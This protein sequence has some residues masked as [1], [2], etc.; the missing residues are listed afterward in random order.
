MAEVAK[1]EDLNPVILTPTDVQRL[2]TDPSEDSRVGVLEK[3]SVHYNRAAFGEREHEIA[4]QIFRLLMKDAAIRVRETLADRIKNNETI[5][6]DI[7]LHMAHDVDSV[8]LPLLAESKVFS[9][10]DLVSIVEASRDISKLLTISKRD[11]VSPRVSDALVETRYPEVV[12]T[13]LTN[14]TA[15]IGT[16]AF[17]KIIDD[18]RGDPGVMESMVARQQ[19]PLS[20]VERLVSEASTAVAAQLKQKYNLTDAQ[21]EKDTARD[22]VLMNLLTR[23]VSDAEIEAMVAQMATENRLTPSLVMTALCRGQM[24]FF[25]AAM[26]RFAGVPLANAKRLVADKGDLGLRGLYA[27]SELPPAMFDAVRL[28]LRAVQE[29]EGDEAIP[30]SMLYANRLVEKVL[31]IAGQQNIEYLPYFIA[32][33]RQNIARH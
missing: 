16:R 27:K 24:G 6:R 28:L 9:D 4:E 18:F 13:L 12:S 17:E 2:L 8:A 21:L 32:L 26:G 5:P 7:V 11:G 19:L 15:N 3:V 1:P 10:A 30:G 33:I 31:G 29:L 14:E 22:D 25:A 20:V 23:D